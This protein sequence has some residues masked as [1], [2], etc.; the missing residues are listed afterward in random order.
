MHSKSF[1]MAMTRES[2]PTLSNKALET[3]VSQ[4]GRHPFPQST[5]LTEPDINNNGTDRGQNF[6]YDKGKLVPDLRTPGG[7]LIKLVGWPEDNSP[8]EKGD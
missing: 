6:R 3:N 5:E 2:D 1:Y 8:S 4:N 7:R